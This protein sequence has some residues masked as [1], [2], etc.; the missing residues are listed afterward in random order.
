[1]ET[2]LIIYAIANALI[3]LYFFVYKNRQADK[4]Y[5]DKLQTLYNS[6]TNR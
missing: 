5:N 3:I 2:I 4:E 6:K 1:M